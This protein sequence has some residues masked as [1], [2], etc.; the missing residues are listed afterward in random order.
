VRL[1]SFSQCAAIA[2]S[3]SL[4]I[5]LFAFVDLDP[6]VQADFFFTSDD[7]QFRDSRNIEREFGSGDQV[8][9]AAGSSNLVSRE[10]I[11]LERLIIAAK[12][13]RGLKPRGTLFYFTQRKPRT[14]VRR[15]VFV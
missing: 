1:Q 14:L 4:G 6:K 12:A 3:I 2:V 11:G 15:S 13:C 7:P 9:I 5:V 8:F 10:Y